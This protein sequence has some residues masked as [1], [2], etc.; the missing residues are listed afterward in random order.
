MSEQADQEQGEQPEQAEAATDELRAFF[1]LTWAP[2]EHFA[3][4]L[5]AEG[6]LRGLIGP[7]EVP[8]L[9]SRHLLNSAA[10]SRFVPDE[11]EVADIGSGAGF[12][13]VV[14]AI[15]RPDTTV[16]LVEPM[17]RRVAWLTDVAEEV[18]LDN[19]MIHH[20]RAEELHGRQ[21]F[22]VVTA[23]AVAALDRLTRWAMPLVR[24][25]GE[26]VALKGRRAGEELGEARNVLRKLGASSTR[27]ETVTG[28]PLGTT[29]TIV[30]V[31]KRI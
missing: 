20:A 7:R 6:E 11:A 28:L 24:P 25:G 23:R 8:R 14:L 15:M 3:Q 17:E 4:M 2:M 13:G 16:H 21:T 1:G 31:T 12:P 27:V 19:V 29:A 18:G 5:V 26:L 10:I 9:W 30:Q 22:D